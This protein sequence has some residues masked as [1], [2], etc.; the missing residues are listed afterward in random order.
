MRGWLPALLL[1]A[2]LGACG[3]QPAAEPRP[4]PEASA[5]DP[6]TTSPGPASSSTARPTASRTPAHSATPKH[7]VTE[8]A[9][10]RWRFFSDD[11]ARHSSPWFEGR[12]RV[13][14]GYGCTV[15][16]YY[17]H[18]PRCPGQQ[19][20]HHGIDVAMPCGPP[21][22]AAVRG[23]VLDPSSSGTPAAAYGD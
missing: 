21:L 12:H 14:I 3:G 15:A 20:F 16:P 18:D 11:M 9:D 8:R 4:A 23:V 17:V 10:P 19:G 6:P 13:M 2:L 5:G 1:L 7:Q 22:L